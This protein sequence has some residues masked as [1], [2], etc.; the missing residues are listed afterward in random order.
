[1]MG[2]PYFPGC[3]LSTTATGYDRSGR[4]AAAALGMP[5]DEI[6]GWQCCG[7]TFPLAVDNSMAFIAPTRILTQAEHAGGM[8]T[9]LCVVCY[10]VLKRSQVML[11]R[12][13][14]MLERINWFTEQPYHGQVRVTHLLEVLRDDL[15][16]EGLR[17]AV[18][19][20]LAG[21]RVAPYYGCLLLRPA[22]EMR[23]DDPERPTILHDCVRALGAEVVDFP[24]S[25]ECCGS[26]LAVEKKDVPDQLS[27][28]IVQS[29]KRSGADC[30]VT[31]CPLCQYNLDYPQRSYHPPY[32]GDAAES[33]GIIRGVPVL[34]FTQLMA[35][36]LD[37]P[38]ADWGMEGLYVDP[39]P[40]FS[41]GEFQTRPVPNEEADA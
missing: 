7:A 40:L 24:Y 33:L 9:T 8:V 27:L 14:E 30:I 19:R 11:E 15:T 10:H 35:V 38:R 32:V 16:W 1:M 17:A 31:A 6:E 34:Y 21:L 29:A 36:A 3:T 37:L 2:I 23:L 12:S 41:R 26:Y 4:A 5:L 25:V 20:P 18:K 13:P 28:K 22:A 39:L